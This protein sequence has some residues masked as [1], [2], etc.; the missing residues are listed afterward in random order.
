[1]LLSPIADLVADDVFHR[2]P[3]QLRVYQEIAVVTS[4]G[5]PSADCACPQAWFA[6]PL[7]LIGLGPFVVTVQH[8]I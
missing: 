2:L 4:N 8:I 3:G 7:Y 1:M 6:S 5:I